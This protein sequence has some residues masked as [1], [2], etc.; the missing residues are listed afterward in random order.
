M[1]PGRA[2][3]ASADLTYPKFSIFVFSSSGADE[4]SLEVAD[5]GVGS[6]ALT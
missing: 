4:Q 5:H 2:S 1:R 6:W 3:S